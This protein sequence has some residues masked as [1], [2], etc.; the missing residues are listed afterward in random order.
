MTA[1]SG[2]AD[3]P[4]DRSLP[5]LEPAGDAH[6]GN[7]ARRTVR[8]AGAAAVTSADEPALVVAARHGDRDALEQLLRLHQPRLHTLCRRLCQNPTDALDALQDALIAIVRGLPNFDGRAS[9]RT[10]TYRVT[11]NACLDE[12]RRRHRRPLTLGELAEVPVAHEHDRPE[13]MVDRVD[14]DRALGE[15]APDFRIAVVL[16]DL[17]RL[18]YAEIAD[19]LDLPPGTVRSRISRGRAALAELLTPTEDAPAPGAPGNQTGPDE[20]PMSTP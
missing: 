20:R 10:W 8:A 11:T 12:L 2:A 7:R 17:C 14:I 16:R 13:A 9:F 18:D 15:L 19:V 3:D 5:S 4:T 1:P 6:S